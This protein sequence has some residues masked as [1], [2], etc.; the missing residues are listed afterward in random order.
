MRLDRRPPMY[1]VLWALC[2]AYLAVT[3][4]MGWAAAQ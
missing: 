3:P 2:L 1:Y 4:L